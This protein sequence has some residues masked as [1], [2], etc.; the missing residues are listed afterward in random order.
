MA[1][2]FVRSEPGS[3]RAWIE[4]GSKSAKTTDLVQMGYKGPE[5]GRNWG[6]RS[7]R[8]PDAFR[9]QESQ[10]GNSLQQ[11][12]VTR[13]TLLPAGSLGSPGGCCRSRWNVWAFGASADCP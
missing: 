9:T 3:P 2:R 13:P 8:L 10:E 5:L 6:W 1:A 12:L 7:M 4:P 11:A